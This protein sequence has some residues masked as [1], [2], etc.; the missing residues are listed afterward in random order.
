MV[1]CEPPMPQGQSAVPAAEAQVIFATTPVFNAAISVAFLGETVGSHTVV[2]GG[3]IIAASLL[4]SGIDW[5][6]FL[7][8]KR[9]GGGGGGGGGGSGGG[10]ILSSSRVAGRRVS[11]RALPVTDQEELGRHLTRDEGKAAGALRRP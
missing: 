8:S 4:P 2:G 3:V 1:E 7:W 10:G 5:L 6:N 11:D 9:G